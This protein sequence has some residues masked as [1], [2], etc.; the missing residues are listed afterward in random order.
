MD[1]YLSVESAYQWTSP[2]CMITLSQ[3]QLHMSTFSYSQFNCTYLAW[4]GNQW[5]FKHHGSPKILVKF[6]SSRCLVFFFSSYMMCISPSQCFF[7]FHKA[8]WES[9]FFARVRKSGSPDLFVWFNKCITKWTRLGAWTSRS[10]HCWQP[11]PRL[12][13]LTQPWAPMLKGR[14][15][16]VSHTKLTVEWGR[17]DTWRCALVQNNVHCKCYRCEGCQHISV[18]EHTESLCMH[19]SKHHWL[20]QECWCSLLLTPLNYM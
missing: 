8:V 19:I 18:Q 13:L 15:A 1:T 6:L 7:F 9:R 11:A 16:P 2:K 5:S 10:F 20:P 17:R 12:R 14:R 3:S 4:S